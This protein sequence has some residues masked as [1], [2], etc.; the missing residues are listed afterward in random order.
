MAKNAVKFAKLF[1]SVR[2]VD[3]EMEKGRSEDYRRMG[4]V[5]QEHS[6]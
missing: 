2:P 3:T 6:E 4:A 5:G 1:K